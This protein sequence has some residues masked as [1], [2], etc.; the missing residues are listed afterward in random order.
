[1]LDMTGRRLRDV[2]DRL[3]RM[4]FKG[5]PARLSSLLLLLAEENESREVIGYTHQDLA[6]TVGTYS[7]DCQPR[8]STS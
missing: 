7:R 6:E 1:M 3:T 4:A 2:E 5:I 8:C